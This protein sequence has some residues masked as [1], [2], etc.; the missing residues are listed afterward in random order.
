[1]PTICVISSQRLKN[2]TRTPPVQP[3]KVQPS[4]CNPKIFQPKPLQ[5]KTFATQALTTQNVTTQ[6]KM[7]LNSMVTIPEM[8]KKL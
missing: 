5:P 6:A 1:M 2:G 8:L 3:K 4:C 7:C